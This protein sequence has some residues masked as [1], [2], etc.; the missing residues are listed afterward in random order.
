[1]LR[2]LWAM[3]RLR[4]PRCLEG[5]VFSGSFAMND[6]CPKCG[7]I[8]QREEGYFLGAMYVSYFLSS[9]VLLPLYFVGRLLWPELDSFLLVGLITVLYL[10]AVPTVFRYS[11]VVW[12]YVDRSLCAGDVSATIYEKTKQREIERRNDRL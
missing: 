8:F 1:M 3:L 6:P 9:A 5:K 10:P 7:L 12:M 11:R 4:C 2:Q